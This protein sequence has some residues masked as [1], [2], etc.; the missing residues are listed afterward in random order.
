MMIA[1][2]GIVVRGLG[3][4]ANTLRLQWSHL[5]QHFPEIRDCHRATINVRLNVPILVVSPDGAAPPIAWVETRPDFIEGFSF[6]RIDLQC[7]L[8]AERVNAW[9]YIPHRSPHRFN[10]NTV[11]IITRELTGTLVGEPCRVHL[12]RAT[13]YIV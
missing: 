13:G 12:L 2:D 8:D 4:A 7:P 3:A 1:I 11:E 10:L 5:V 6:L 9:I